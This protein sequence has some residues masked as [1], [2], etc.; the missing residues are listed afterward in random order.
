M[1]PNRYA[2]S[3]DLYHQALGH[4]E[5]AGAELGEVDSAEMTIEDIIRDRTIY[6]PDE[7]TEDQIDQFREAFAAG[8]GSFTP[9]EE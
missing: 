1:R 5:E 7:L 4:V 3:D 8:G 2:R 9:E 6:D